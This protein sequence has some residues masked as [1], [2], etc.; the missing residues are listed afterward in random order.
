MQKEKKRG[1]I[2][3]DHWNVDEATLSQNLNRV[4][5]SSET[6]GRP[7]SITHLQRSFKPV[8]VARVAIS[9]RSPVLLNIISIGD[10]GFHFGQLGRMVVACF[11]LGFCSRA[12]SRNDL[13]KASLNCW[14]PYAGP[15]GLRL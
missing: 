2:R 8:E 13:T 5:M 6:R 9:G 11:I 15:F 12:K 10:E 7:N 3:Y 1:G 4:A 14:F